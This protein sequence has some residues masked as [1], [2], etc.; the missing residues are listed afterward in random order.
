MKQKYYFNQVT[1]ID[2]NF[3][4]LNLIDKGT[5]LVIQEDYSSGD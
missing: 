5:R 4:S 3:D 1:W 2:K